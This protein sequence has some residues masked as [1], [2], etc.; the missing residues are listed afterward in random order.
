MA[1]I[2]VN[3]PLPALHCQSFLIIILIIKCPCAACRMCMS[4][5]NVRRAVCRVCTS[6]DNARAQ[7]VGCARATTM[8]L[9]SMSCVHEPR[10]CPCAACR[11]CHDNVRSAVC[12]VYTSHGNAR[13]QHV[14]QRFI[15][16]K[17]TD[18]LANAS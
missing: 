3:L 16:Q 6:H 13:A 4:H 9:R 11:V 18:N 14:F 12:R 10:Q 15:G 5:D 8:L 7:H 17:H 2:I 1:I